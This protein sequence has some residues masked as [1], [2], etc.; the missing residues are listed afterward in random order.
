MIC[1]YIAY[2][3]WMH[4]ELR[5]DWVWVSYAET[6]SILT[7]NTWSFC[8][9]PYLSLSVCCELYG[10]AHSCPLAYV[11]IVNDVHVWFLHWSSEANEN[12]SRFCCT[13]HSHKFLSSNTFNLNCGHKCAIASCK[14]VLILPICKVTKIECN[15]NYCVDHIKYI[16]TS[17]FYINPVHFPLK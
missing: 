12:I 11:V 10:M 16:H 9:C 3:A 13:K 2:V 7:G 5:V 17:I 14:I 15:W 6:N 4:V 8:H 1:I